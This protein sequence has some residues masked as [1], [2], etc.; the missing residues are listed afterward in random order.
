MINRGNDIKHGGEEGGTPSFI[1]DYPPG[2]EKIGTLKEG[3]LLETDLPS[4]KGQLWRNRRM[5]SKKIESGPQRRAVTVVPLNRAG[6]NLTGL[7]Q[8]EETEGCPR[9]S[10]T[11]EKHE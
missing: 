10:P 1:H 5:K 9:P 6:P 8:R 3:R 4:C 11:L 2:R 7:Q